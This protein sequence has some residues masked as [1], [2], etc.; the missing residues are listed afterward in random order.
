M[1]APSLAPSHRTL[2]ARPRP[3]PTPT[4]PVPVTR[5]PAAHPPATGFVLYVDL[6]PEAFASMPDVVRQAADTLRELAR[7][8]LP[9]A[10]TRTVLTGAL[11][12]TAT[13][14][15]VR[16]LRDTLA[17]IPDAPQVHVDVRSRLLTVD[18][19]RVH[20]TTR[21]FDLLAA[22]VTAEGRVLTRDELH[23]T[24]WRERSV[25]DASRT[26]DVHVRRLRQVPALADLITTARGTG[27]RIP[28][29]HHL[30]VTT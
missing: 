21:E 16:S 30:Q 2:D 12:P 1:T 8:W 7:E 11:A 28:V 19:Q 6:G 15:P 18:G 17:A 20:L 10:R 4:A 5:P 25:G 26:V 27:Y 24:V 29:R 22:L 9:D 23:A 13:H 14:R 3:R